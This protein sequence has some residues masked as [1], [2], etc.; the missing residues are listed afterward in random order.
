MVGRCEKFLFKIIV[1]TVAFQDFK[2][3]LCPKN[4]E[5]HFLGAMAAFP[6]ELLRIIMV[7]SYKK[8]S[9]VVVS[10]FNN[11]SYKNIMCYFLRDK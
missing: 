11:N 7:W 10:L 2:V 6:H 8:K 9:I 5:V 1:R 4:E 3:F